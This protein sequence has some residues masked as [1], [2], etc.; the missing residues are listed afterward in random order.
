ML[1]D[2]NILLYAVDEEAMQHPRATAW[3]EE[4][5]NGPYRIGLPWQS[6]TA[7]VRISTPPRAPSPRLGS[8]QGVARQPRREGAPSRADLAHR[9]RL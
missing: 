2:A 8:T 1:V 5:L 6:L 7:F 4:A 9:D 3:L